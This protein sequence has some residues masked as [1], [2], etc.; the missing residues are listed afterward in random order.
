MANTKCSGNN[1]HF[2]ITALLLR[3]GYHV[4]FNGQ[5]NGQLCRWPEGAVSERAWRN[6]RVHTRGYL[7]TLLSNVPLFQKVAPTCNLRRMPITIESYIFLDSMGIEWP[8][9]WVSQLSTFA[10]AV[11]SKKVFCLNCRQNSNWPK[12]NLVYSHPIPLPNSILSGYELHVFQ[13]VN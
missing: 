1:T 3:C 8:L 13:P 11:M 5:M 10:D 6:C 4:S 12:P 9:W 7:V 2:K